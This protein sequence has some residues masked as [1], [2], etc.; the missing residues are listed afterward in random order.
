MLSTWIINGS[1]LKN[2]NPKTR[3]ATPAEKAKKRKIFPLMTVPR[4]RR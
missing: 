3:I 4:F 2:F 1:Q